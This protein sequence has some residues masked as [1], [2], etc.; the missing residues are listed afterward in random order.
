MDWEPKTHG[1]DRVGLSPSGGAGAYRI[2][3]GDVL[4]TDGVCCEG[5]RLKHE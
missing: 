5:E 4:F 1:G 2:G 3:S